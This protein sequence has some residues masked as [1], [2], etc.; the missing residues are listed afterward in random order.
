MSFISKT[1]KYVVVYP[2]VAFVALGVGMHVWPKDAAKIADCH[3]THGEQYCD[4]FGDV[5]NKDRINASIAADK[6]EEQKKIN[7]QKKEATAEIPNYTIPQQKLTNG[8]KEVGLQGGII[9]GNTLVIFKNVRVNPFLNKD[10]FAEEHHPGT[11]TGQSCKE[12][13]IR[14][15]QVRNPHTDTMLSGIVCKD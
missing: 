8:L 14:Y 15:I 12:T 13:G 3:A 5:M 7:K 2:A 4:M 1:I 10:S 11:I 9:G 6:T